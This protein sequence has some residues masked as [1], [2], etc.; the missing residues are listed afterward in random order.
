MQSKEKTKMI[1]MFAV[2]WP[3]SL[4]ND[5][6]RSLYV[7][8]VCVLFFFYF[9]LRFFMRSGNDSSDSGYGRPKWWFPYPMYFDTH[10]INKTC[11]HMSICLSQNN[12]HRKFVCEGFVKFVCA[13]VVRMENVS[14][15]SVQYS[16][17]KHCL[18][19]KAGLTIH[20]SLS[21]SWYCLLS[22]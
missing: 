3:K 12:F 19:R 7:M 14:A 13:P 5:L 10:N 16:Q 6:F 22:T 18:A 8:C 20:Y 21:L 17:R 11:V 1:Y 2:L 4:S 9:L 15:I